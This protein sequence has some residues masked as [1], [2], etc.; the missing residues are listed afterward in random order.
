MAETDKL[1]NILFQILADK[2]GKTL[3]QIA[4]DCDRDY[5]LS[6]EEA[7]VYGLIDSV[8]ENKKTLKG[9]SKPVV[10]NEISNKIE[11]ELHAKIRL[12]PIATIK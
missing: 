5:Y 10:K 3:K 11:L 2:T 7:K 9:V 12:L 1:E 8:I 4:K 6:S